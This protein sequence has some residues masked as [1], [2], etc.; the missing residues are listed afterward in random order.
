MSERPCAIGPCPCGGWGV[1][2]DEQARAETGLCH[3]PIPGAPLSA[4]D[5]AYLDRAERLRATA[6]DPACSWCYSEA[7]IGNREDAGRPLTGT[8]TA[9]GFWAAHA[10]C[11]GKVDAIFADLAS[12]G[13]FASV[14]D[15]DHLTP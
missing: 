6:P 13:V 2:H 1:V 7:L 9:A 12:R 15:R 10:E 5:A 3:Q 11:C 4:A 14:H 8:E